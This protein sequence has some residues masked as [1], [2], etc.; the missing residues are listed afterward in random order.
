[1]SNVENIS[2][3]KSSADKTTKLKLEKLVDTYLAS[4]MKE[5][6]RNKIS[7]VEI[8]FE[9]NRYRNK[10]VSKIDYDNVVKSLYAQ[11]FKTDLP[12]GFHSLR[13]FHEYVDAR[14]KNS[15]S[16]I[17]A[18][19]VGLDLIQEY[20]RTNSIQKL[21]ELPSST[22]DKIKFTQK[23]LPET[24]TH[25]KILPVK[26]DDFNLKISYQLEQTSTAR[27]EFIR[28]IIERWT[29]RLKTFRY[30]N[31]VRFYHESLPIFADISIV[32]SS[33]T[34]SEVPMKTYDIQDSGVL[35]APEAYEIEVEIDNDRIGPGTPYN[36]SKT[37][38]DL[39]KKAIRIIL[40]GLQGTN[41]PISYVEKDAILLEYMQLIH[42]EDYLEKNLR[43]GENPQKKK[44]RILPRDFIG[45]SSSTLQIDNIIEPNEYTDVPNIRKNYTVTDKADGERRLLYINKEGKIYMIDTNMNVIFTGSYS[46]EKALFNSLLD[47]EFIKYDKRKQIINLFAAFDVYYINKKST[48]EYAFANTQKN[49][50]T[51]DELLEYEEKK[52]EKPAS[53]SEPV[54]YRLSLLQQYIGRLKPIS[55]LISPSQNKKKEHHETVASCEFN[56]KCKMFCMTTDNITI[57]QACSRIISDI[58]D[59][60]YPYNTDGLIFTPSNTAV[61]SNVVG[62][63]GKLFKTS[64]DLSFKWKPVEFNTIDFLVTI[65]KEKTGDKDEIHNIF[66]EGKNVEGMQ[67]FVQYKTLILNCGY[68]EKKHGYL[69]PFQ[70]ILNNK[71][72]SHDDL[73][74]N[75]GYKPVKFQPS[76]PYNPNA[77]YANIML[78]EDG[79][80]NLSLFTEDGEYFEKYMIVEFAYDM[81]RAEGWK[82]I[83]LRVR[84]DKTAELRNGM[85][86]YG[87]AYHV[88]NNN[89]QSI[90]RP[91]TKEMISEGK[92]IPEFL[93]LADEEEN[94]EADEGVYYNRRG[95]EKRT[96]S[97][98]NFHNLFVK[99]KLIMGVSK[100]NDILIDFAVGKAGDLSKWTQSKLAFVYGID[101]SI[102]NI[103]D[104]M[105]GACARYLKYREKNRNV[106]YALFVNGT[107]S[108]N[109]RNGAAFHTDKDK[110]ITRA[111]FGNGPKDSKILGEGVYKQYGVAEKGFNVSS[112]QF[113]LHYFWEN[114]TTLH[115]FLRNVV[116]CTRLHGYFIGTCYDGKTVFKMLRGKTEGESVSIL[117]NGRKIFELTKKY[118]Q[119]G[120]P[121]DENCIGYPIDVY[122]ETINKTFREYLVNFDY[123]VRIMGD[124][125][126]T[127]IDNNEAR[128]MQLPSGSGLFNQLFDFMTEET[129]RDPRRLIDYGS[130]HLMTPD[131]KQISFLNRYFVFKKTTNVNSEKIANLLLKRDFILPLSKEM[132]NILSEE[133]DKEIE[134]IKI[135][136]TKGKRVKITATA[137]I[138]TMKNDKEVVKPTEPKPEPEPK[139]EQEKAPVPTMK[140]R[141]K[142]P[143]KN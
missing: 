65:K 36:N 78:K 35:D 23:T 138:I 142:K 42:G 39:I 79:N 63:A 101:I 111:I 98:R 99:R 46:H 82:W 15:M 66:Q 50:D 56:I 115:N 117:N 131:E 91:V 59:G 71:L 100:R 104:R 96:Q 129:K 43:P 95:D 92:N 139:P 3:S 118:A 125:G 51:N 105:D 60:T 37:I 52:E 32:K 47:G 9:S 4:Y 76:N 68:D 7:E 135:Q 109:V 88:A 67:N 5:Q 44:L 22:Y 17:R 74:N 114:P 13:I 140:I 19:I 103:H 134:A 48:R 31:R 27:S 132:Q 141:I 126:F 10:P 14:G 45:P 26:F 107:S 108:Q 34:S 69:Q 123:L 72:P 102:P 75:A 119:T 87:N 128:N 86:N 70:D 25:E 124:Y 16:N 94:V 143:N 6:L 2:H 20:C 30:L 112:C 97:L 77:C 12:E 41:Y 137:N 53:K 110:E 11:G 93:E 80:R 57:F 85:K 29:E 90:H 136:K 24:E 62:R 127:L 40:S 58:D 130:A 84:Y 18:E 61:G 64:W 21:L 120:L 33:K 122:Q 55:I 133:T 49:M 89:W 121:D 81:M 38:I 8:R 113:A 28:K 1:M 116:E 106:P 83:P 54:R 73:D